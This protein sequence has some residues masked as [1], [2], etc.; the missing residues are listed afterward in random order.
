M[1]EHTIRLF[2]KC[3]SFLITLCMAFLLPSSLLAQSPIPPPKLPRTVQ[4]PAKAVPDRQQALSIR[5]QAVKVEAVQ[6]WPAGACEGTWQARISNPQDVAIGKSY[7]VT[8]QR[9]TGS[10]DWV[11]GPAVE[12]TLDKNQKVTVQGEWRQLIYTREFKVAF[13]PAGARQAYHEKIVPLPR[14]AP[15][16][17]IDRIELKGEH[18]AAHI[19]NTSSMAGCGLYI[20]MYKA[21]NSNPGAFIPA[22]NRNVHVPAGTTTICDIRTNIESLKSEWDLVKLVIFGENDVRLAEQVFPIR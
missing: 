22:A 4:S 15:A 5:Y 12:F 19:R 8:Y 1:N 10:G 7:A 16:L 9:G 21:K 18:V 13:K 3:I 20:Q 11:E 6:L 14:G 17:V 2:G